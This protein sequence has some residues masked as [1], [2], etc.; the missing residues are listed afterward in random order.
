MYLHVLRLSDLTTGNG[1]HLLTTN[2]CEIA[3][4]TSEYQCPNA[5]QLSQSDWNTW[6]IA[7]AT[8]F[9]V[10]CN[11]RLALPLGN[12]FQEI[13]NGWYY[14]TLERALWYR[15]GTQWRRH[16]NIPSRSRT[17]KFHG[18]GKSGAPAHPL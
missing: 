6:E 17:Q 16:G 13:K 9:Q 2:W 18:H 11:G 10:G 5:A 3:P 8:A 14:D 1:D 12:Y 4:I 7:L 15:D